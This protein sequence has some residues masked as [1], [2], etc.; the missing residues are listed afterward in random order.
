MN[1]HNSYLFISIFFFLTILVDFYTIAKDI[2]IM[3]YDSENTYIGTDVVNI[4]IDR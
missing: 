2:L 4:K 1:I 3:F